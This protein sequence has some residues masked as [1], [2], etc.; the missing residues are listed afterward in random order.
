MALSNSA[1]S[2]QL[3]NPRRNA[4]R[5]REAHNIRCNGRPRRH[6][7]QLRCRNH[8]RTR[9]GR[10]SLSSAEMFG[11]CRCGGTQKLGF[12][13]SHRERRDRQKIDASAFLPYSWNAAYSASIQSG[14]GGSRTLM[15]ELFIVAYQNQSR[16]ALTKPRSRSMHQEPS[17][18][19]RA[20]KNPHTNQTK[21][22]SRVTAWYI[23]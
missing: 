18:Q 23:G 11:S 21:I 22:A 15:R 10:Y 1:R 9:N 3:N 8:H 12:R 4:R 13:S 20:M 17:T 2:W 14:R 19:P 5:G 6:K 7:R 16:R